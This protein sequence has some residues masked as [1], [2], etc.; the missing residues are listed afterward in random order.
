MLNVKR[1]FESIL[2]C[3]PNAKPI[4]IL[5]YGLASIQIINV[6]TPNVKMEIKDEIMNEYAL[7]VS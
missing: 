5:L 6:V 2:R 7:L 3:R 4:N 1:T